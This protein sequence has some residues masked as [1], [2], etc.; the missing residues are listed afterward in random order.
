MGIPSPA[1]SWGKRSVSDHETAIT[2][3]LFKRWGQR[4]YLD[5]SKPGFDG[6]EALLHRD[7]VHHHHAVRLAKELLGDAAVPA[8]TTASISTAACTCTDPGD[9]GF[10]HTSPDLPCPR[11]AWPPAC[12]PASVS[13]HC[14]QYLIKVNI[15]KQQFSFPHSLQG[16]FFTRTITQLPLEGVVVVSTKAQLSVQK[17]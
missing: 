14:N 3:Q 17:R 13:S 6:P 2:T 8:A 11:A 1:A 5:I 16:L 15:I 12:C 9:F 10:Q 7:V 4:S